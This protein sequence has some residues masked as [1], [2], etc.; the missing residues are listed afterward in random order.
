MTLIGFMVGN[1]AC[2]VYSQL[3]EKVGIQELLCY[4]YKVKHI[5][6]GIPPTP[7]QTRN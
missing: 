6:G 5:R 1:S 3:E 7:H 4:F 2:G